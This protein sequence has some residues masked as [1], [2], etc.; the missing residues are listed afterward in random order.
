MKSEWIFIDLGLI[1]VIWLIIEVIIFYR[2]ANVHLVVSSISGSLSGSAQH[3]VPIINSCNLALVT[4]IIIAF[5]FFRA[6]FMYI[7][8]L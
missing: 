2:N 6:L 4:T 8:R 3:K 1:V 5:F 7:E